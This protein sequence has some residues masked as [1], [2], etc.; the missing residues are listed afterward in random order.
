MTASVINSYCGFQMQNSNIIKQRPTTLQ[1]MLDSHL[2]Q[3]RKLKPALLQCNESCSVEH[4]KK[5]GG[6]FV[7]EHSVPPKIYYFFFSRMST[8]YHP[9]KNTVLKVRRCLAKYLIFNFMLYISAKALH[10]VNLKGI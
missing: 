6:V 7:M 2:M 3:N 10:V 4:K 5:P 9:L 1:Q 8:A